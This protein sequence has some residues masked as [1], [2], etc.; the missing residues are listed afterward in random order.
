[1]ILLKADNYE[2]KDGSAVLELFPITFD[3]LLKKVVLSL[4]LIILSPG[5]FYS[6]VY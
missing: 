5:D 2:T 6:A 3:G 1:M 4:S